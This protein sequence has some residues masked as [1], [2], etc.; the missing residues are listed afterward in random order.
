MQDLSHTENWKNESVSAK[1]LELNLRELSSESSYPA[2]WRFFL[3]LIKKKGYKS[4]L[5]IGCGVGAY[6]KLIK[7]NC[8]DIQ[9]TGIDYSDAAI[10]I[11]QKQW[12]FG[13]FMCLDYKELDEDFLDGFDLVH[14]GAFLD[15]LPNGNDALEFILTKKPK[16]L[17]I[18]RIEITK[19]PSHFTVYNA[20][21]TIQTY[22]YK[23][24]QKELVLIFEKLGYDFDFLG[25][26]IHLTKTC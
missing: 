18:S 22:S 21:D 3:D 16:N 10:K 12:G 1:Q 20:Y 23:H 13:T 5:D 2:H 15:V 25:N 19:N 11:A 14:L 7:D 26:N 8:P 9:Y 24:N 6:S 17:L 4:I